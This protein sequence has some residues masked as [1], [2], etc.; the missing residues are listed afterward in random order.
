LI[1][2]RIRTQGGE[3]DGVS[4][5]KAF[6][7]KNVF[8]IAALMFLNGLCVLPQPGSKKE[9]SE[10]PV[11][12]ITADVEIVNAFVTV[13]DKKG[14]IVK[15]LAQN[16]FTLKEDGRKQTISYFSRES[17]LPLTIGLI[18]DTSPSMQAVR[19]ELQMASRVFLKKM[20]RPGKDSVFIFKFRDV[21]RGG[22]SF[23]GQIELMQ[24][25]TSSEEMIDKAASLIARE[26]VVGT[27]IN[28]GFQTMLAESIDL[29]S[30]KI[31]SRLKGRK[32][33]IV[34]GDGFHL[35]DYMESAVISAQEAD[36]L[37]YT[38][39]IYDPSWG[40]SGNSNF[41]SR[42]SGMGR[43]FGDMRG[44][45]GGMGMPGAGGFDPEESRKDLKTLSNKTGGAFFEGSGD[46][47]LHAIYRQ[48]EEELR[49]QYSLG[50]TPSKSDNSGFRKIKVEVHKGGMKV[51]AREGYYPSAKQ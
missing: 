22:T 29:A 39:H 26:D 11:T 5:L 6:P 27:A 44:P 37:I 10:T 13:R 25:L 50:Y 42:L 1:E 38:I 40:G 20:I 12:T 47:N 4:T 8:L 19:Q 16:D 7:R 43:G 36:A 14:A 18:I 2:T 31:L 49:S 34:I 51:S 15:D 21:M 24:N 30:S 41:F 33:L 45:I 48:I 32:A 17:D 3:I 35:D 46:A 23:A 28:A 9:S